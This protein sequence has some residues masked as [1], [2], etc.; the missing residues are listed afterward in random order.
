MRALKGQKNKYE[1][2]E[3]ENVYEEVSEREYSERVLT[4]AAEDWIEDGKLNAIVVILLQTINIFLVIRMSDG[5]GYVEDGREIFDDEELDE[6]EEATKKRDKADK[7]GAKKRLRDVNKPAEGNASIRSMFGNVS[8]KK[9]EAKVKLD[10]DDILADILGEI[11]P[12]ESNSNGHGSTSATP[13][14]GTSGRSSKSSVSDS[15]LK[16]KT[17]MAL[18]K[19]YIANI[20]KVTRKSNVKSEVDD[21]VSQLTDFFYVVLGIAISFYLI[22]NV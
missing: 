7:K 13:V 2:D 9:K 11:N 21:D 15:K 19:D 12:N 10:D 6:Q 8:V 3:I 4:R 16:E 5:T 22:F 17:E 20:S 14:A 1:V 18:V